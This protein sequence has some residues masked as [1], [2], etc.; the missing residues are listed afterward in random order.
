M[1]PLVWSGRGSLWLA[2][3]LVTLG[4][5]GCSNPVSPGPPP[6]PPPSLSIQ[7]PADVVTGVTTSLSAPIAYD[8]PQ[9]SG[10]TAPV[11]TSCSVASGS[12]FA[13]GITPVV[14]TATDAEARS[15]QCTFRVTVNLI[16][17]LRGTKIVTFGDSITAGEVSPP[18]E[19]AVK[20]FDP[21][22]S[23]PTVLGELLRARYT[24]QT[25]TVINEGIPGENVVFPGPTGVS[26]EDRIEPL[27]IKHRPDVFIIL[28]GV[29][30]LNTH[31]DVV[32]T[33]EG[34]RRGARRAVRQGVPLVLVSTILPGV[35]GRPCPC[36]PPNSEMVIALN[37]RIR[38]W[39]ASEGAV[40][41]DSYAHIFP[42]RQLWI[43][44]DG[45]HPTVEGYRALAGHFFDV[46]RQRFEAPP[47]TASS[48]A[49]AARR[50][51][52]R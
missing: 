8:A 11:S 41:V 49:G 20:Y 34:L 7:C 51:S 16:P 4:V 39:A 24:A 18:F 28:E 31:E 6:P 32:L 45:L 27:V 3:G 42:Q 22:S 13:T 25:V 23:Y 50:L 19:P 26:G 29:N 10:G 9:I 48:T 37:D 52:L 2:A 17:S 1:L 33:S 30:G 14:C 43:G 46:I 35:E 5:S 21:A 40:L 36:R 15:S 12:M 44:Q 47:P 38:S